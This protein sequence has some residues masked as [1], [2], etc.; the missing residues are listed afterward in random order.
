MNAPTCARCGGLSTNPSAV[1]CQF[2]GSALAAPQA[3]GAAPAAYGQPQPFGAAPQGYGAPQQGYGAPPGYGAPQAPYGAPPPNA[4][5]YGA[6]PN[7]YGGGYPQQQGYPPVQQWGGGGY[8]P[9]VVV[10]RGFLGS[11]WSSGW[12]M[13]WW[14]RLGIAGIV[15]SMA[16][17]GACINA[18]TN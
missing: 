5:P 7:P 14:I 16:I 13:F 15:I 2:C 6:P 11:G 9:Q 12:S 3:Y 1:Q 8:G 4:Y 10:N 18:I 17:F